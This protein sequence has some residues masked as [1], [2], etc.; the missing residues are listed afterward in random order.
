MGWNGMCLSV[1]FSLAVSYIV[2]FYLVR[3]DCDWGEK[4]AAAS[5]AWKHGAME[6]T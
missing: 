4:A 2:K 5:S 1:H 3:C 6:C